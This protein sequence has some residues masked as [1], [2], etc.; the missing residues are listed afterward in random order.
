ME[1][2]NNE[3]GNRRSTKKDVPLGEQEEENVRPSPVNAARHL[4]YMGT[5]SNLRNINEN[6]VSRYHNITQNPANTSVPSIP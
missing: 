4:G 6:D 1:L 3:Y 2:L 5:P